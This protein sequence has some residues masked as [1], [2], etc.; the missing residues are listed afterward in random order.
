MYF[1]TQEMELIIG[2]FTILL[3]VWTIKMQFF[4]KPKEELRHLMEQFKATQTMSLKVQMALEKYIHENN[5]GDTFLA[6]GIRCKAYLE[7]V[8]ISFEENL[9]DKLFELI[10]KENFSRSNILSMT[11]SLEDQFSALSQ[12][13]ALLNILAKS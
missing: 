1:C 10:C 2:V 8:K 9:S 11:K 7:S 3:T 4:S 12:I 13:N 6:P 5:A